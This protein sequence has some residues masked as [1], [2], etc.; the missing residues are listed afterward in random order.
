[1]ENPENIIIKNE[2]LKEILEEIKRDEK[3]RCSFPHWKNWD[4][5]GNWTNSNNWRN[6]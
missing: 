3:E 5:W 1:M 2:V 6:W 4:N